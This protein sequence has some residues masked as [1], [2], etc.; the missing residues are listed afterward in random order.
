MASQVLKEAFRTDVEPILA[1]G[2]LKKGAAVNPVATYR[3]AGYR[4]MVAKARPEVAAG[5]SGIV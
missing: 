5:S 1:M 2:R 3:K 4:Q